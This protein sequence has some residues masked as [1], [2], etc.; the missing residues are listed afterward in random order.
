MKQNRKRA[1]K[2]SA[3]VGLTKADARARLEKITTG[4]GYMLAMLDVEADRD[5]TAEWSASTAT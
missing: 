2:H 3:E 4:T 5:S 1:V